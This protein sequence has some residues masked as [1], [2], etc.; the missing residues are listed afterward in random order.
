MKKRGI[1]LRENGDYPSRLSDVLRE[2]LIEISDIKTVE[3]KRDLLR[4]KA[5]GSSS[6]K[7][8]AIN[9]IE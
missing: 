4:S 8:R 2:E 1:S 5:C 7:K 9:T 3:K 6:L